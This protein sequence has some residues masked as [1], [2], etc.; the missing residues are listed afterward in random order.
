MKD[1]KPILVRMT[2]KEATEKLP[3]ER[4]LRVH[5]SYIVAI[6]AIES[7]RNKTILIAK[8]EIPIGKTYEEFVSN[9]FA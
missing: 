6:S 8:N 1:K 9:I 4:F 5:K 7:I 2:L 3:T